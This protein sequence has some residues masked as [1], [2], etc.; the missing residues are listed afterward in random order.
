MPRRKRL[1]RTSTRRRI[2]LDCFLGLS[3]HTPVSLRRPSQ[4]S[5]SSRHHPRGGAI[6]IDR[7]NYG[8]WKC[9]LEN[10][11]GRPVAL[12]GCSHQPHV[13]PPRPATCHVRPHFG[14]K[15]Q[16]GLPVVELGVPWALIKHTSGT[17]PAKTAP[18]WSS[19][20]SR[21]SASPFQMDFRR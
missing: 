8:A 3:A 18:G 4:R 16:A 2:P 10:D 13:S 11:A 19:S 7:S 14:P 20:S 17:I 9:S 12:D 1:P 5:V 15:E 6:S 21:A